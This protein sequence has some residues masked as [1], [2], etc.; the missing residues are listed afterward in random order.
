ME[1]SPIYMSSKYRE[2]IDAHVEALHKSAMRAGADHRLVNITE[3]LDSV[4]RS[5]L[6]FRQTARVTAHEP[7]GTRVLW[8]GLCCAIALPW[9]L[10]RLSS[11]NPNKQKFS[12]L[13]FLEPG[14]PR[15][16]LAKKVQYLLLLALRIGVLAL[17]ALAFAG[18]RDLAHAASGRRC[19]RRAAAPDRARWL[20]VDRATAIAG[21]ARAPPRTTCS[22]TMSARGSRPDRARGPAVR[23]ARPGDGRRRRAAPDVEH[24]RAR[25][26]PA[27][28]RPAH[29]LDRRLDPHGRAAGRARSRHRRA[30]DG[31]C[32]RAS[33]SSRRGGPA[34]I[35]IHDVTD[36]AAEKWTVD[37]FGASALT[38]EISASVRSFAPDAVSRTVTL[39]QNGRTV[40]DA[41]RRGSGSAAARKSRSRR[42]SSRAAR[43]VSR[44]R[45]RRGDDLA[46][47]DRRYLA[48][49]RAGAPQG[50]RSS[51]RMP[52]ARRRCSRAP[53]SGR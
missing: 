9:W 25:R 11:D 18:A 7:A 46:G 10:H 53:R 6:L 19:R 23:G 29:A 32:R 36:G 38:G 28:V 49:K 15:R 48:I 34:E 33:A 26:V 30:G 16:V 41:D 22:T 27:R 1:V 5:Y 13:M 21:T 17:L 12:S 35:V 8:L 37:S 47:D 39:T 24:G 31:G 4:L 44:S 52:R 43:I 3:P 45:S 50:S 51:R 14:E 20:G 42:S 40:G 2:R